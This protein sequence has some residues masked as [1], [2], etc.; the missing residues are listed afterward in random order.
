MSAI[1]ELTTLKR[2][3]GPLSAAEKKANGRDNKAAYIF[4]L[5]WLVGLVAI[6]IGPML[7]SLYLSF[8]DYNL[9]QP[10]RLPGMVPPGAG[11]RV[12]G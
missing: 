10:A 11:P 1:G 5:P 8:T 12:S 9:L 3:K 7:M 6:T 2:R 4:L